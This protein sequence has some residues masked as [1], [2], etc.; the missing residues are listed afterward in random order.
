MKIEIRKEL[1]FS[2][3]ISNDRPWYALYIDD[4]YITGSYAH[5]TIEKYY[6]IAKEMK[7]NN[8]SVDNKFVEILK[9]EEI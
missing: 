8:K 9:S 6:E 4:K 7:K 5:D 1:S 2:G 3:M